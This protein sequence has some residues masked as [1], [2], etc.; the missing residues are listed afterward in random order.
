MDLSHAYVGMC[1]AS[2]V[3]ALSIGIS[4][5]GRRRKAPAAAP[6][7][8]VMAGLTVGAGFLGAQVVLPTLARAFGLITLVAISL[9]VAGFYAETRAL[10]DEGWRIRPRTVAWLSV[11]PIAVLALGGLNPGR[12]FAA[13]S[14]V[15]GAPQ[16]A[17]PPGPLFWLHAG[18]SYA[19]TAW[20]FQHLVRAMVNGSSPLQRRQVRS[21]L[22]SAALPVAATVLALIEGRSRHAWPDVTPLSIALAGLVHYYAVFRQG[23][24]RLLPVARDLVVEHVGDA[25]FVL[26]ADDRLVDVNLASQRLAARLGGEPSGSLLGRPAWT[27]LPS[28]RDQQQVTAGE[29]HLETPDGPLDLDLRISE[30]RD[31]HG[32]LLG[33]VVVVRDVTELNDQRRQLTEQLFIIDGLRSDLAEQSVRDDLTGLHNR[34]HLIRRLEDDL[35]RAR[36]RA[37]PL[38]II[39]LDL[40]DLKA[41][42][43]Q[44]GHAIGDA[45]LVAIS[46]ALLGGLRP[47]QTVA[48]FGGDEFVVLLPDVGIDEA[49]RIAE[50]LRARCT[51]VRVGSRRGPVTTTLSGGLAAFPGSGWSGPE[52]LRNADAALYAAKHAGRDRVVCAPAV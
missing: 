23:L 46:S 42:N 36:S 39:I 12:L 34:R 20:C 28:W 13:G 14:V 11:H 15:G 32:R 38:S 37:R 9:V 41:I 43:D 8:F 16:L 21:I 51:N 7:A 1:T 31:R 49:L 4:A 22:Q 29:H 27:V 47:G 52:L 48:R 17:A 50:T 35:E 18:Y 25:I 6:L 2:M 30:V 3:M 33:R 45:L 44:H 24:L 10:V 5:W 40:D 26:D 19:L